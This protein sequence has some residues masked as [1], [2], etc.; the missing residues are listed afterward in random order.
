M[1]KAFKKGNY[2]VAICLILSF[3]IIYFVNNFIKKD[4]IVTNVAQP[5]DLVVTSPK[6][7]GAIQSKVVSLGGKVVAVG[8]DVISLQN[9]EAGEAEAR[10]IKVR[11]VGEIVKYGGTYNKRGGFDEKSA[12]AIKLADIKI[13]DRINIALTKPVSAAELYTNVLSSG[14]TAVMP[15]MPVGTEPF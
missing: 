4:Q 7:T 10:V 13:G 14:A 12:V 1:E 8:E 3:T 11:I 2:L 9:E 15:A 6:E 5:N